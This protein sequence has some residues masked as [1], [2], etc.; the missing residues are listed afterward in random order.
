MNNTYELS[1]KE[2]KGKKEEFNLT[3]RRR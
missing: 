2:K 1:G 3:V